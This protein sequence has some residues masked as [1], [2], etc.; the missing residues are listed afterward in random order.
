M[1]TLDGRYA[2][3]RK[4]EDKNMWTEITNTLKSVEKVVEFGGPTLLFNSNGMLPLYQHLTK[5]DGVNKMD[6]N[7]FQSGFTESY[8]CEGVAKGKSYNMDVSCVSEFNQKYDAIINSHVIEHIANPIKAILSW[9]QILNDN[10]YIL[11]IIPDKNH[12]FDHNRPLTSFDHLVSDFNSGVGEDDV[13]HIPE[14]MLLNDWSMFGFSKQTFQELSN[15][16]KQTKVV[17]HHC[18]DIE[19]VKKLIGYCELN[20]DNLYKADNLT[21][22]CLC[23]KKK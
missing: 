8:V 11:F 18:F 12:C 9:K 22:I 16:N 1:N 15:N 20:I 6:N 2:S 14:Q 7:P 13:T 4:N 19:L 23:S 3:Y 17:H 10:G 21:I 5:L